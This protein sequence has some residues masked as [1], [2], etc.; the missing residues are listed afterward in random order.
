MQ[1]LALQVIA[2]LS[3]WMLAFLA[4]RFVSLPLNLGQAAMLQGVI[5]ALLTG[6]RRMARWWIAIQLFFPSALLVTSALQLPPA[7]YL[8]AFLIML[9]VYWS[10]FRTQV[11]YY[12]CGSSVWKAVSALLPTD[13]AVQVIDIGSG[14][15][16]L[17]LSLA[18]CRADSTISG[19]EVAPLPWLVSRMRSAL[20]GSRARFMIGDYERLDLAQ[21][22]VVFAYLSPA[23]M[24][25]LWQKAQREMRPGTLL[26]SYE[27][28]IPGEVPHLTVLPHPQGPALYGWQC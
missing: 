28:L 8:L 20:A 15:G 4:M 26:L 22:D 2:V 5:A 21:F 9:V 11:P 27:F 23:A 12:P 24:P 18:R 7:L 10:T 13:R 19:I 25:A 16:G 14:L 17:V 3:T 1:A 6:W